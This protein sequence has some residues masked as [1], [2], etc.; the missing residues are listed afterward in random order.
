MTQDERIE[1]LEREVANLSKALA[2]HYQAINTLITT[3]GEQNQFNQRVMFTLQLDEPG[4]RP[5]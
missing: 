5:N 3:Q 1:K 4:Q 2:S